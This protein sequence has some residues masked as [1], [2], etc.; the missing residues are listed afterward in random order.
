MANTVI[1]ESK[2]KKTCKKT[3][4]LLVTMNSVKQLVI[5]R[6]KLEICLHGTCIIMPITYKTQRFNPYKKNLSTLVLQNF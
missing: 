3:V 2:I 1:I 5:E 4:N 6:L